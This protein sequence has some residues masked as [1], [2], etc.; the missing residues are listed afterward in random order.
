MHV[1]GTADHEQALSEV[2]AWFDRTEGPSVGVMTRVSAVSAR[3]DGEAVAVV[4]TALRSTS[5]RMERRIRIVSPRTGDVHDV[6]DDATAIAWVGESLVTASRS[7]RMRVAPTWEDQSTWDLGGT[8]EQLSPAPDSRRVAIVLGPHQTDSWDPAPVPERDRDSYAA[9][10]YRSGA[11]QTRELWIL[12]PGNLDAPFTK[13]D[14]GAWNI[15]ECAWIDNN[16]VAVIASALAGETGWYY[17]VVGVINTNPHQQHADPLEVIYRPRGTT[18]LANIVANEG[19]VAI[20]EG[21]SSD[22]GLTVGQIVIAGDKPRVLDVGAEVTHITLRGT[23]L[24]W[25]GLRGLRTVAGTV[26]PHTDSS[27][28]TLFDGNETFSG[29]L[30]TIGM[31]DSLAIYALVESYTM[32]PRLEKID[33][34]GRVILTDFAHNGARSLL[35]TAGTCQD[36]RWQAPDGRQIEGLVVLP[37]GPG[38][39]PMLMIVHGGPVAAWRERWGMQNVNR[40]PYAGLLAEHGVA[41]F[42]PNPRGSVGRGQEFTELVRGDMFG[43]D[44]HDLLTG[45]DHLVELGFADR[46][47]VGVTGN[48]Y[49]GSMSAWLSSTTNRFSVAIVTS[50]AS[51]LVS[52][53]HLSNIPSFDELF[54]SGRVETDSHRYYE[55]SPL[56]RA[57]LSDTPTLI[58]AGELDKCTPPSQAVE[59]HQAIRRSGGTTELVLY[60]RQAHGIADFPETVDFLARMLS[61]TKLYLFS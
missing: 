54:V 6:V 36:V 47:R 56:S 18:Q 39:H 42:Y 29:I 52:Q 34:G 23:A 37:D 49:G 53:H 57:H 59:L 17:P 32:A 2:L 8:A 7:V 33:R 25:A 15:W 21:I 22:R 11:E 44:V 19:L 60:P 50:P 4:G 45:I 41:T 14:C 26:I 3:N 31:D 16:R 9:N 51:D 10:V 12:D 46:E 1:V 58:T 55:H 40:H 43:A 38:P 35:G 5:E 24:G 28:V 27:N 30:P 48:S 20:I 61:W 13:V